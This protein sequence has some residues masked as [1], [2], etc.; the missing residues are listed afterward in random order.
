MSAGDIEA[1]LQ[2]LAADGVTLTIVDTAGGVS[3]ATTRRSA[4]PICA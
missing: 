2:S 3:A 1:A 4:T